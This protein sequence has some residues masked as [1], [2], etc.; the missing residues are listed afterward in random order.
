M[1]VKCFGF[2][3]FKYRGRLY[4]GLKIFKVDEI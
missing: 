4:L 1:V 3:D 2:K